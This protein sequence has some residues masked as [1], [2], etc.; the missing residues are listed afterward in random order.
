MPVWIL[1]E[2]IILVGMALYAFDL[3]PDMCKGADYFNAV[4]RGTLT[5]ALTFGT[6]HKPRLVWYAT[7][8]LRTLYVLTVKE[9]QSMTYHEYS[10]T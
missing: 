9:T 10:S 6:S 1:L 8:I 7:E 5:L 3:T 2:R 4:Q